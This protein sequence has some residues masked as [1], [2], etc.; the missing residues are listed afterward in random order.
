MIACPADSCGMHLRFAVWLADGAL[1]DLRTFAPTMDIY[2]TR[3][4][5]VCTC[6]LYE[7]VHEALVA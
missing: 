7:R 4:W 1:A 2:R 6:R 3:T 5:R